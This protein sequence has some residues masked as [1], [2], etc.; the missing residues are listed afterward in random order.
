MQVWNV[1]LAARCKYG[2]QKSRKKSPSA[3]HRTTLSGSIFATQVCVD[4]RKKPVKQQYL[5]Q[6]SLSYGE[7]RPTNGWDPLVSLGNP[8]KFQRVSRLGSVTARHSS[9]G[10]QPKFAAFNRRHHLYSAGRLSR[11]TL[12]HILVW[13]NLVLWILIIYTALK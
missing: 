7:L 5:P 2:T 4:N 6:M 11:W 3:H 1:L 13:P 8:R 9:S 10:R 12:A